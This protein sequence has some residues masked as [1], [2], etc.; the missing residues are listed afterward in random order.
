MTISMKRKKIN[1][2]GLSVNHDHS[3]TDRKLEIVSI[4]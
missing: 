3:V 1:R 2:I 4:R